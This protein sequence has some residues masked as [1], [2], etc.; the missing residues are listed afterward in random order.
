MVASA[1]TTP[2]TPTV[3]GNPFVQT[4]PSST[5]YGVFVGDGVVGD[6]PSGV[7]LYTLSGSGTSTPT[8]AAT[9]SVPVYGDVYVYGLGGTQANRALDATQY[10]IE[11]CNWAVLGKA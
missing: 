5:S 3:N 2:T 7:S 10:P 8:A 6:M 1:S 11:A 4:W 9:G